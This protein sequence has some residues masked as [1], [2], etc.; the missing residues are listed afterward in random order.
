MK[1]LQFDEKTDPGLPE[2]G[3]KEIWAEIYEDGLVARE[4]GFAADG[5]VSHKHPGDGPYGRYG[6]FDLVKFEPGTPADIPLE[7]FERMW[8]QPRVPADEEGEP[9]GSFGKFVDWVS[10]RRDS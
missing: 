1:V 2:D 7:E 5:S 3:L 4:I 9:S 10:K 6:V 8:M